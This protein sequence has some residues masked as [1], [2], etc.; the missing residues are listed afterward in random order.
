[1]QSLLLL[2]WWRLNCSDGEGYVAS[3]RAR[4]SAN[5]SRALKARDAY[6]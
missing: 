4:E 2:L 6:V 3:G 5:E 1:M